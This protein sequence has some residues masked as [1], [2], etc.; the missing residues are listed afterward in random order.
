[1]NSRFLNRQG[2]TQLMPPGQRHGGFRALP[3]A[4]RWLLPIQFRRDAEEAPPHAEGDPRQ[5]GF[6]AAP[7]KIAVQ[8]RVAGDAEAFDQP[9]ASPGAHGTNVA[10]QRAARADEM[11]RSRQGTKG[12]EP[13]GRN[14]SVAAHASRGVPPVTSPFRP[15]KYQSSPGEPR[16]CSPSPDSTRHP[17]FFRASPFRRRRVFSV[18]L[19]ALLVASG[20][21]VVGLPHLN[22]QSPPHS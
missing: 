8:H 6:D 16:N 2:L 7:E 14:R 9:N 20:S 21:A 18:S 19:V 5:E 12:Q 13:F 17:I 1:M 22:N 10:L 15:F 11:P 3:G 4:R